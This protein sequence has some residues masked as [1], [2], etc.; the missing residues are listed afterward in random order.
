MNDSESFLDMNFPSMYD[1]L[2]PPDERKQKLKRALGLCY[3][4][5][6]DCN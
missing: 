2:E 3:D 6:E 4:I 5:E 1:L